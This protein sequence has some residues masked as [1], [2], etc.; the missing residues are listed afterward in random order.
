MHPILSKHLG[1]L[2]GDPSA[3]ASSLTSNSDVSTRVSLASEN[4]IDMEMCLV[5]LT[6]WIG[7]WLCIFFFSKELLLVEFMFYEEKK[8][9]VSLVENSDC[10]TLLTAD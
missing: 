6:L 8:K 4:S 5:T 9:A 1:W 2:R 10:I 7:F 3:S